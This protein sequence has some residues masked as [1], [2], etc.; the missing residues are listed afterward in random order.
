MTIEKFISTIPKAELHVH[1]EGTFEPELMFRI[2][3][4]NNIKIK[5]N[6]IDELRRAYDFNNLQEFLDIYYA[7]AGV[8][9]REQDFYDMTWA[10][11][12]KLH[13]QNVCH[14]EIFFDPQTHTDRTIQFS[15]VITGIH[16]AL[17]RAE[18][19]FG[20]STKLILCFL[21]HLDEEQ[22]LQTLEQALE[23]KDWIV[24][25]GLDSSEVGHPPSK[26]QRVFKK[27]HDEGFLTVAHAGE[28]GP[29][30]YVWEAINLLN[31]TRIDHGNRALEDDTLVQ[32]LEQK[33]IPL[34]VCPLSNLK[35]R[36]VDKL[37]NHPLKK[38]MNKNLLVTINSDDPAYFGGQLNDNYLKIAKALNL[39]TDDIYQLA[40]NSFTASFLSDAEKTSYIKKVDDY[41]K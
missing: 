20:L 17:K 33:Q 27:A 5:Y 3:Q 4:R 14:A 9:I 35:L 12:K 31:V 13:S 18:K 30:E 22:A 11:M 21:R 16:S 26:F 29:P 6:S 36:V 32:L 39:T 8:L 25:I 34:T 23:F 24:A 40:K 38:I 41:K 2:A 7:G 19:E 1:I 15:T 37:E 10:Y 28:E